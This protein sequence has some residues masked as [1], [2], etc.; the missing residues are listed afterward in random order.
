V[1]KSPFARGLT[2]VL[3][4][5][6]VVTGIIFVNR[7]LLGDAFS[8]EEAQHALYGLW[9]L[10][11]IQSLD[12]VSFWYDTQRQMVWPFLH[13]WVLSFFFLFFGAGYSAARLL[14][15]L[16]YMASVFMV[17]V[18]STHLSQKTGYKIGIVAAALALTSPMMIHYASSNMLEGLGAFLFLASV[19]TYIVCEERKITLE[20]VFLAIFIGLSIYTNYI[21]AYLMIP[22][23]MLMTIIKIEPI[24][25]RAI[26]LRR[27]G[28]EQAFH[29]VWWA[30][31]KLIA[32]FV[33]LSL[34]AVW[35]GF[36]FSR[37]L[38]LLFAA[39][40]KYSGGEQ[41][42]GWWP[43]LTYYPKV[44]IEQL[45]FSPWLG[46]FLLLSLFLPFI[47][48][49]YV[50]LNKFFIF[51]WTALVLLTFTIPA[52]APQLLYIVVPFIF[53]IFSAA[54][55][56]F[57]EKVHEKKP[58]LALALTL[59]FLVPALLSLPRAYA[60]FFP[61]HGRENMR[62]VL[63]YYKTSLPRDA[64]IVIPINLAHLNPEGVEFHF[65]DWQAPIVTD[66]QLAEDEPYSGE[67]YFLTLELDEGSRYQADVIDDSLYR[68]NAQLKEK[69]MNGQVRLYSTRRF[70]K[71][72]VTAKIYA[73]TSS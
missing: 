47:A 70:G 68:W 32:L 15:L 44:I 62:T 48:A 54:L 45:T 66:L 41:V 64:S 57:Y 5:I 33:L 49:H 3:V 20:Y 17:Y 24:I 51:V 16:L 65:K 39:I 29:F 36:S 7:I 25:A 30:Y 58:K 46:V 38:L 53:M 31:R 4:A 1:S 63:E 43:L 35:F 37:K 21:Y 71:I 27:Q 61:G 14:S 2:F 40:F 19:Y 26:Q 8:K 50:G 28:E 55:F 73:E 6:L 10:K 23:F 72:G 11:D 13:S 9:I 67:K 42:Y 69:Q 60:V 59:I 22:A 12:L 56:Y 52:K 34:A 18:L